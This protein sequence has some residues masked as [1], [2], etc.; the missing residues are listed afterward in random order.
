MKLSFDRRSLTSPLVVAWGLGG[1]LLAQT[2]DT[3]SDSVVVAAENASL[4]NPAS[5]PTTTK[6]LVPLIENPRSISVVTREELERRG[7]QS[8]QESVA[9]VPGV[10]TGVGG[11][12]SRIDDIMIRGFEAGGF[13]SNTYLDGLRVPT[14]GQWTTTQFDVFGLEQVEVLKGPA[15]VLFGQVAPGG[16]VNMVSKRPQRESQ[17]SFSTQYGSFDTWQLSAD[18]TGALDDQGTLLYRVAGLYREGESQVDHTD[19]ERIYL[20]PSLTWTI[21]ADTSLTLLTS[22]QKDQGGDTYQFLPV[23][24]TLFATPLGRID[25]ENFI[26]EPDFNTYDREQFAVGYEFDHRFSEVFSFQQNARY[27]SVDT[28]YQSVVAGRTAPDATGMMARR[29]VEGAGDAQSLTID[30]RLRADFSTGPVEHEASVGF[31]YLRTEWDHE[32]SGSNSVAAINVY[33][34]V[35]SG[36]SGAFRTQVSQETVSYQRGF[37]LQDQLQWQGWHLSAGARWDDTTTNLRNRLT[38]DAL[39]TED[40]SFTWQTGLLH[41]FESGFSPYL[42]Y[43]TSFEPL[44]GTDA[45]GSAFD[46]SEGR[47][48]E[49]GVKYEPQAWPGLFTLSYFDLEQSNLLTRDNDDPTYQ[50]QTGEVTIRGV[51]FEGK[52]ELLPGLTA[53]GGL[54]YLDAEITE[55]NDGNEGNDFAS[56][57]D[58]S[59]SLWLDYECRE[60]AF[61]G[62]GLGV[63][64]R[65]VSS[66][67]GD[68]GNLYELPSYTLLDAGL[69]YDLGQLS[70]SLEGARLSLTGSNLT[71]KDYVAKAETATSANYGPA[72]QI[73]LNLN[74]TW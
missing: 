9:Y 66:R 29:A 48:F 70:D 26:G 17:R 19:L 23:E 15:S 58:W 35:Y 68:N 41:R 3:L 64:V 8:V 36:V 4:V 55:D 32:R 62:L 72:R 30:S 71:D 34:P 51:E 67:A 33:D 14:G 59:A 21:G 16:L 6:S 45:D 65:H 43:A 7:A 47:Q 44:A 46:P 69:R 10:L 25:R 60:G 27:T 31:D 49:V 2:N 11:V 5:S 22:Y 42:S 50:E 56:V 57:P 13:T 74:Y 20:A 24:G 53:I 61:A 63:G 54:A 1:S 28:L 18:V 52:V 73:N 12:D 38:D 39:V 37:Y 40:E